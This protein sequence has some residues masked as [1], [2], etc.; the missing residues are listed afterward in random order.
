VNLD[1]V[2][3]EYDITAASPIPLAALFSDALRSFE[4]HFKAAC[5][6]MECQSCASC[7][8]G[9]ECPCRTLFARQLSPDPEVVK[10]H[11]KPSLPF[12]L[13]SAATDNVPSFCTVGMV[14]IGSALNFVDVFNS[15]MQRLIQS[16]LSAIAP[17]LAYTTRIFTLDYQGNRQRINDEDSLPQSLVLLSAQHIL[18]NTVHS[19]H[20][21]LVLKSPLRLVQN[22]MNVHSFDF[23]LLFR[24][25]LRRCS[26]LY[27]Y[28]GTGEMELDYA[29]LSRAAHNV[30]VLEDEILYTRPLWAPRRSKA[31]LLGSV[32]CSGLVEPMYSLLLLGSYFN[33]GKGAAFGSGFYTV[34]VL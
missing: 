31:G 27:A 22:G 26:S 6:T 17:S 21:R 2:R 12:S 5:C 23:A 32:E 7:S 28:Y 24:S 16:C 33:A 18:Q 10:T 1:F 34:E 14:I 20:V 8:K 9:S 11:Q 15:A 4:A 13:H 25:Q 19:D 3:I 29:N 30:T